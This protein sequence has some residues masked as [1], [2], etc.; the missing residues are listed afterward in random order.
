M[1]KHEWIA[2]AVG[3]PILIAARLYWSNAAPINIILGTVVG[4]SIAI[5]LIILWRT[6]ARPGS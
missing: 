1:R 4:F 2:L 6:P 3:M 5:G